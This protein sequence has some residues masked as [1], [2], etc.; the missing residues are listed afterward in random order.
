MT[1]TLLTP[2]ELI[3]GSEPPRITRYTTREQLEAALPGARR[4]HLDG[5][6]DY[7]WA[8]G[9]RMSAQAAARRLGVT[10]RT[11]CRY[12]ATLRAAGGVS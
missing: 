2:P 10:E 6:E 8:G 3:P 12:R 1:E 11:V 5:I 4:R 9:D 7:L